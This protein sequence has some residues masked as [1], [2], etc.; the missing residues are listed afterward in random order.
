MGGVTDVPVLEVGGTHV[1]AALV[2]ISDWTVA[3]SVRH[4][5][6]SHGSAAHILD[7]F[8]GAGAILPVTQPTA[9]G[10]AMPDPFDYAGGIATFR[11]VG[12]FDD[13]YGID[14]GAALRSH[15][16]GPPT[17]VA[18]VNDADAFILGEWTHGA[19][20]GF[21]RCVGITLGTGLGSGWVVD[22]VITDSE[23]GVPALG[24]ARNL[25]VNGGGLEE[26]TS[27]RA[28][29]RSYAAAGGDPVADVLE[30]TDRARDGDR[31]ATDVLRHAFR[32]LGEA[33]GPAMATFGAEVIVVGGS[34]SGSWDLYE[35]WFRDG[36]AWT[37]H[38][39]IRLARDPEHA[40]MIGAASYAL[41]SHR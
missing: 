33:M 22:G 20:T 18:F 19:A 17:A 25:M 39:P 15:L 2:H 24:R 40:A 31:T 7:A 8:I 11:D 1:S 9:W 21:S 36:M 28:I 29:R 4:D 35:P 23:P 26:T 3:F 5:L 16:P 14:V 38:P 27:R 34:M 30:I 41:S 13:L 6:D 12:K 10:V 32:G 37:D